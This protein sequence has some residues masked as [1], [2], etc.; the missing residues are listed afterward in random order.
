LGDGD[1]PETDTKR[2]DV[3]ELEEEGVSDTKPDEVRHGRRPTFGSR[4]GSGSG[5]V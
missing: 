5:S 3:V 4:A 1:G 2:D